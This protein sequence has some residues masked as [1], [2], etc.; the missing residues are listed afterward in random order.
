MGINPTDKNLIEIPLAKITR[1]GTN[2]TTALNWYSE[3]IK[4]LIIHTLDKR[5]FNI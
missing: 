1:R 3:K 4:Q 2:F 5:P